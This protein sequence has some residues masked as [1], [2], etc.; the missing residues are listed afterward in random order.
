MSLPA[1]FRERADHSS[2]FSR[3]QALKLGVAG[4]LGLSLP[5]C[6]AAAETARRRTAARSVLVIL[7]QGG[8]SHMDT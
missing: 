5:Q 2:F 6:L 1:W 3:R 4:V 8:L 7:E